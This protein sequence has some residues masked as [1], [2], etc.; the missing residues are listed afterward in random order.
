MK[1]GLH[2]WM[3]EIELPSFDHMEDTIRLCSTIV[4]SRRK[5]NTIFEF[6]LLQRFY[7]KSNLWIWQCLV[8][9]LGVMMSWF[10]LKNELY[11]L[12]H[13]VLSLSVV[14]IHML[15]VPILLRSIDHE[16]VEL[17]NVTYVPYR[18][19]IMT[20]IV[21]VGL[22]NFMLFM[23][24]ALVSVGWFQMSLE[25]VVL[26]MLVPYN[27]TCCISFLVMYCSPH[28]QSVYYSIVSNALF[29]VILFLLSNTTLYM[30]IAYLYIWKGCLVVSCFMLIFIIYQILQQAKQ[31]D[32]S[33]YERKV[34]LWN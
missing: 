29:S 10:C 8:L 24:M 7:I 28:T 12:M 30:D 21:W 26:Y 4:T 14:M 16:T 6:F 20:R 15:S 17:E 22:L 31:H 32:V 3:D 11:P 19:S 18:M 23:M 13:F 2:E 9:L 34:R 33:R 27:I 5:R 1:N 25:Q